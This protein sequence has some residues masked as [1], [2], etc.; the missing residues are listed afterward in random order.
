MPVRNGVDRLLRVPAT[1]TTVTDDGAVDEYGDPTT[2][3]A[4]TITRCWVTRRGAL[5]ESV[6]TVGEENWQTDAL[7]AYLP[8]GTAVTGQDRLTVGDISWEV[9]GPAHEHI[10]PR[11][12]E[13]QFVSARVRRV[14]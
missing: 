6:E 10:D 11:T 5:S 4:S 7:T 1:L 8:A 14:T 2:T 3:T 12:G 13:G 9:I